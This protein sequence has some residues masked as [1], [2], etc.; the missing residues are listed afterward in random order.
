MLD[1]RWGQTEQELADALRSLLARECTA[2]HVRAAEATGDGRAPALEAH[3]E[4]FGLAALPPEPGLL[5]AAAWELGRALA[6]TPF[7]ETA[8]VQ[9]VLGREQVG[10]GLEGPVPAA[11]ARAVVGRGGSLWLAPTGSDARRTTAG[12]FLA[13]PG[14]PEGEAVGAR[15]EADRLQRLVRLLAAARLV[16]GTEALLEIGVAHA[17]RREQFG[18]PIGAFQAVAHRLADAAVATD[19][20]A[21]LVRKAAWVAAPDQGGDGAPDDVFATMAWT[22]AVDSARLVASHVHQ[23]MGGY[24]FAMEEDCQLYSRRLRSWSMRLGSSGPALVAMARTLLDPQARA[25]VRHLWHHDAGVWLP[26]WQRSL[27]AGGTRQHQNAD[28]DANRPTG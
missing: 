19:G 20:A 23:V 4:A 24:G 3:L 27:D 17:K 22:R 5:A 2:A 18:R 16:G 12:D 10:Y 11:V 8:P 21:L 15:V 1:E 26:P 25:R 14:E 7:V 28:G 9:A 6:P 13:S